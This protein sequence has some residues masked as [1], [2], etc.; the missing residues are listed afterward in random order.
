MNT[1]SCIFSDLE[2]TKTINR[3]ICPWWPVGTFY[4][5]AHVSLPKSLMYWFSPTTPAEQLLRTERLSPGLQSSTSLQIKPNTQLSRFWLFFFFSVD[6][7]Q[8]KSLI[9]KTSRPMLSIWG[10]TSYMSYVTFK[11]IDRQ[12][13]KLKQWQTL[14]S[15]TPKSLQMVT[16][17]MKLED[18][19]SLEEKLWHT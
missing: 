6:K 2:S 8:F 4:F 14:F 15:W 19:C 11:E 17:A 3:G 16:V 13:G 18:A 10:A 1:I 9:C 7:P 12:G 5:I